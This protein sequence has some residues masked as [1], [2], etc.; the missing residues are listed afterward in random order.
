M[1]SDILRAEEAADALRWE[2]T[3]GE[4]LPG[5]ALPEAVI[6]GRLGV[7]RNT[8]REAFRLLGQDGLLE[9]SPNRGAFVAVPT[10]GAILDIYRVRRL[11]EGE[12]VAGSLPGHPALVRMR[13]AVAA[14]FAARDEDDWRAV[15]TAN[16]LFHEAI[17]GLADSPR[18]TGLHRRI[19]A[20]LRLAF[21]LADDLEYLH[22]PFLRANLE[23]LEALEAGEAARAAVLLDEC[24]IRGERV[25]LS[26][27][28]S[29]PARVSAG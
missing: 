23:I 24:L 25:L 22:S 18:L 26:V 27:F 10:V 13:E 5:A 1:R 14:S 7:S 29:G 4:L 28:G 9:H 12:A 16:M 17:V 20:E 2:I 19:A 6:A 21:G 8:L 15:G 11:V 3:D